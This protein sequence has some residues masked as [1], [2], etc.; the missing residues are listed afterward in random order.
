MQ[1][2]RQTR[3]LRQ[4]WTQLDVRY[5]TSVK[6]VTALSLSVVTDELLQGGVITH[7]YNLIRGFAARAPASI[8][9]TVKSLGGSNSVLVEEDQTVT[10]NG[11]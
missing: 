11:S 10:A 1:A 5:V 2:T 7:E 8:L 6:S 4:Q 3:C 9:D